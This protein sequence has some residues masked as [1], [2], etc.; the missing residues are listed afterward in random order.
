MESA[1]QLGKLESK[2]NVAKYIK[3]TVLDSVLYRQLPVSDG[4]RILNGNRSFNIPLNVVIRSNAYVAVLD[5]DVHMSLELTV[6]LNV[7]GS[8]ALCGNGLSGSLVDTLVDLRN[9]IVYS[10]GLRLAG[11]ALLRLCLC[12]SFLGCGLG[13][14]LLRSGLLGFCLGSFCRSRSLNGLW[15]YGKSRGIRG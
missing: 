3:C 2:L 7:N 6:Q 10:N 5:L 1:E 15:C 8:L 13:R 9:D 11:S 4:K 14:C 12:G